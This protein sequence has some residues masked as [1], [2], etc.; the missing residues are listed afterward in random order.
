VTKQQRQLV[1]RRWGF[2]YEGKPAIV[3][4]V[5]KTRPGRAWVRFTEVTSYLSSTPLPKRLDFENRVRR[6]VESD[7]KRTAGSGWE[8]V[9]CFEGKL[10]EGRDVFS[11]LTHHH[12]QHG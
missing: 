7:I 12:A 4:V 9:S 5:T 8:I 11:R 1:V 6:Q 3:A 2:W 10:G